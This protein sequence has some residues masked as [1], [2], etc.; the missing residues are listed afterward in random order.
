MNTSSSA[1]AI[2]DSGV[3]VGSGMLN[4]FVHAYAMVPV[5][6][7]CQVCHKHTLTLTLPC[8]GT[9]YRRHLDHGDTPGVCDKND[10]ER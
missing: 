5:V 9:E 10:R 6:G 4:G 2:N 8:D 1:Q 7:Q 3:I